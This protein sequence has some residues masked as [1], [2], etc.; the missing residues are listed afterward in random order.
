MTAPRKSGPE[1][2][3]NE[4]VLNTPS[5]KTTRASQSGAVQYFFY[6]F[7]S[8]PEIHSVNF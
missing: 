4:E 5:I 7:R 2:N 3:D 6:Y 1:S 8:L